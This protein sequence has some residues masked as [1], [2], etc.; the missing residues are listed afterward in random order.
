[1]ETLF[2]T[3]AHLD[4][5][6]FSKDREEVIARARSE[7]V[8]YIITIGAGDGLESADRAIDIAQNHEQIWT[9]VGVHP[10]EAR[11]MTDQDQGRIREL[12]RH[13]KVVAIGEIGLD[14]AKEYSPR[15]VQLSRFREQLAI[16]RE[17]DIPVVIHN[18]EAH[19]DI[20]RVL[21]EDGIGEAGGIMHCYSGS[22]EM[23][24]ELI[25]MGFYISFPGVIT[26]K[27][28]KQLPGVAREI[29]E[30]KILI[31]TDS[32]FLAPEPYRGKR[33]EPAYV[34]LVAEALAR[35]RELPLA[36][37]AKITT[38]NAFKAFNIT[39]QMD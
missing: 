11:L 39:Q 22:P 29:P 3:H 17:L 15:E 20:M 38:E 32:P 23:A 14:F 18:R 34:R 19:G 28:A 7:G 36:S 2:D 27:N 10:H 33:N 31:E 8:C 21:K 12:V 24:L 4:F 25:R 5:P 35:I 6:Q 1:M 30:D 13:K 9:T 37:I 26:F 16:A